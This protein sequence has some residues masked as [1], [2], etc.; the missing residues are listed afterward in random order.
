MRD[1]RVIYVYIYTYY[2]LAQFRVET[3]THIHT[4][5]HT[6]TRT[7]TVSGTAALS[8]FASMSECMSAK[9]SVCVRVSARE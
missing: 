2:I 3:H 9:V 8:G 5:I 4:H 7:R 6:H 1:E